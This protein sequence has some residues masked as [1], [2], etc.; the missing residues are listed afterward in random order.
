MELLGDKIKLKGWKGYKA[1]LDVKSN[2]TCLY[3]YF[4][5]YHELEVMFHVAPWLFDECR[6]RLI[7]N[8]VVNIIWCENTTWNPNFI[9]STVCHA[10][11]VIR[12]IPSVHTDSI[13]L[14]VEV[15]A[16]EGMEPT[17]P[18]SENKLWG[19][20]DQFRDFLL[21]KCINTER[22]AW[23]CPNKIR[24]QSRSLRDH[25]ILTRDGQIQ[26]LVDKFIN[27]TK[28]Y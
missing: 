1:D 15:V 10:Q 11:V 5:E 7:G 4:T 3:T 21:Q 19:L 18:P 28:E 2:T 8:D 24:T 12:P 13:L 22:A 9:N 26:F 17:F 20:D 27:E 25:H 16:R 14:K 6:K 23:H